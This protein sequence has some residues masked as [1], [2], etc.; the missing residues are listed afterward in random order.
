MSRAAVACTGVTSNPYSVVQSTLSANSSSMLMREMSRSGPWVAGAVAAALGVLVS[1]I[2]LVAAKVVGRSPL[3]AERRIDDFLVVDAD[4][5]VD[6]GVALVVAGLIPLPLVVSALVELSVVAHEASPAVSGV[7]LAS[8][9]VLANVV[10]VLVDVE[11]VEV[12]VEVVVLVDVVVKVLVE[13]VVVPVVVVV[14][15][16]VLVVVEVVLVLVELLVLVDVV[17]DVDVLLVVDEVVLVLVV[18]DDVVLEVVVV[19]VVVATAL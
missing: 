5:V 11:L 18:D 4:V 6:D 2:E 1:A 13:V 19:V 10:L 9:L 14:D 12:V 3:L 7:V 8:E 15:V 17:V 16:L